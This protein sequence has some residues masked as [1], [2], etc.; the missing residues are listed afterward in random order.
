[1]R[2]GPDTAP[3]A[4]RHFGPAEEPAR[5]RA[6]PRSHARSSRSRR[7]SSSSKA[8]IRAPA[9][10]CCWPRAGRDFIRGFRAL[11]FVG[12][13]VTVFGSARFEEHHRYYAMAR[14]VGGALVGLGFTVMTGGGPGVMEGANRGAR[15][16]GGMLRRL[17]HRAA[18][19][20]GPEP[21][22]GP[23]GDLP[24]L[25][26][27][28]GP[29]GEVL[30]RLRRAAGRLRHARRA[31]RSADADPDREDPAV[32]DRADGPRLLA[33]VHGDVSDA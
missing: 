7:P 20:A 26:R 32:P 2:S 11:H 1:M 18:L 30:V 13:C 25:L 22:S 33:A 17:Q 6:R 31:H 4:Q 9:S 19:R 27:A 29:A 21:L 14:E 10:C 5:P 24:L 8:R 15:E 3:L 16:A 28:Q 23:L 12:P